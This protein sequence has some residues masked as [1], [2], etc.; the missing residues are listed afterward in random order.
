MIGY[1]PSGFK[2]FFFRMGTPYSTTFYDPLRSGLPNFGE[3]LVDTWN[4]SA[5]CWFLQIDTLYGKRL[6]REKKGIAWK[7]HPVNVNITNWN[8][9]MLFMGKLTISVVIFNNSATV[10]TRV[11]QEFRCWCLGVKKIGHEGDPNSASSCWRI[12]QKMEVFVARIA[13]F[14]Q[15]IE[16]HGR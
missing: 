11:Y 8:I 2:Q 9:T 1:Q 15:R 13:T 6:H 14:D 7:Y 4:H 3:L 12:P 16:P 10:I 5:G